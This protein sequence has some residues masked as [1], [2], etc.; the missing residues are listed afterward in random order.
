MGKKKEKKKETRAGRE[1][2]PELSKK[3]RQKAERAAKK[4]E[5]RAAKSPIADV[6]VVAEPGASAT[7]RFDAA[8][9]V[10]ELV[11]PV[12][13]GPRGERGAPGPEGSQGPQGAQGV[14]GPKGD[15][16]VGLNFRDAPS[17]GQEREFYIDS[18]GRL[19]FR[20]GSRRFTVAL[21]PI[22]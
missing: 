11:V 15:S 5:K 9:R 19:C 18:D 8:T 7:G 17:D 16:G 13:A 20:V 21:T 4:A 12:V 22:E 1:E 14:Q 3:D 6:R 2:K 10:L